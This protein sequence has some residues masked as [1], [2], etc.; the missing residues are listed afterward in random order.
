MKSPHS[1]DCIMAMLFFLCTKSL[2]DLL[3]EHKKPYVVEYV[4]K[5]DDDKISLSLKEYQELM[6]L[7]KKLS[8]IP[9]K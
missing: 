3:I 9:G 5:N 8:E 6:S 2:V 4:I 7:K 1:E